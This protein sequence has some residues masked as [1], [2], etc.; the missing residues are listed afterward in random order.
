MRVEWHAL[1]VNVTDLTVDASDYTFASLVSGD[2]MMVMGSGQDCAG[3]DGAK[4]IL[5]HAMIDLRG[6]PFA[7]E[8]NGIGTI[9]CDVLVAG[10]NDNRQSCSQWHTVGWNAAMEVQ[11]TDQNQLCEIKCG[12]ASGGCALAAGYLQLK[13]L[14]S[15]IFGNG[16]GAVGACPKDSSS[17]AGSDTL[18]DCRCNAGSTGPD[19]GACTLCA[20]GKFKAGTGSAECT[21]CEAG[22]Y[23][24]AEGATTCLSRARSLARTGDADR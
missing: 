17:P 11:C 3:V 8:D 19:G 5:G 24:A 1:K 18:A 4:S 2:A 20:A 12:G 9:A 15:Q 7:V 14:D 13:V 21:D 6:T 16:T 22:K 10:G 23:S